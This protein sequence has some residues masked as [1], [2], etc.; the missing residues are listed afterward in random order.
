MHLTV[1]FAHVIHC[2]NHFAGLGLHYT[3]SVKPD[4]P[5]SNVGLKE[6]VRI[7]RINDLAIETSTQ[8]K[9]I[10]ALVQQADTLVST[11][12]LLSSPTVHALCGCAAD[13]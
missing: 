6:G 2:P 12:V 3:I 4:S 9:D 8:T 10:M 11:N 1:L 5:A 7:T 13:V